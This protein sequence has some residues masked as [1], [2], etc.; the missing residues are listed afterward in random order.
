MVRVAEVA[1]SFCVVEFTVFS[2][3][4]LSPELPIKSSEKSEGKNLVKF[5][6]INLD[7]VAGYVLS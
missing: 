4:L 3:G 7:E 1:V 6:N 5:N 2:L